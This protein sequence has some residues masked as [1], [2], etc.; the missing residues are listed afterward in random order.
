MYNTDKY[1]V[2]PSNRQVMQLAY[3]IHNGKYALT[4]VYMNLNLGCEIKKWI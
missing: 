3:N 1:Y 2:V 4:K